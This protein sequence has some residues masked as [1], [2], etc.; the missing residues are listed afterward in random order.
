MGNN[1][2]ELSS[3]NEDALARVTAENREH[4]QMAIE[5]ISHPEKLSIDH[6]EASQLHRVGH[7]EPEKLAYLS[8]GDDYPNDNT[9]DIQLMNQTFAQLFSRPRSDGYSKRLKESARQA[10]LARFKEYKLDTFTQSFSATKRNKVNKGTNLIGVLPGRN[11]DT[12]GKDAIVLLGAH[13]DT[14]ETSPGIDDNGSGMVATL[15]V[16]RLFI[17]TLT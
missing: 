3:I 7:D 17:I 1:R 5:T 4:V 16:C 15:E 10:I 2:S 6:R 12:P 14:V 13:Y 8:S 9:A 11:R